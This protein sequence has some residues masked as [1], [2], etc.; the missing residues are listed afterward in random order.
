MSRPA[1]LLPRLESLDLAPRDGRPV[2]VLV[3]VDYN[4][5]MADGKVV[6]DLR[7][8]ES[9]R[10]VEWLL[11][12]DAVVV[13]CSH[14]GRPKGKVVPEL[15]LRPVIPSLRGIL[16]IEA[17]HIGFPPDFEATKVLSKARPGSLFLLENLRFDPREEAGDP[18]F[19]SQLASLADVYVNEA[20]SAS[21]R[22]HAS[23]TGV[24]A[25]LPSAAG[26]GLVHEV[27]MLSR[28]LDPDKR[29][30]VAVLGG[31]KVADKLG[32]VESLLAKVDVMCVGGGMALSFLAARGLEVGAGKVEPEHFDSLRAAVDEAE[33]LGKQVLVPSDLV[34]ADAFEPT[35]RHEV[36][37]A[38]RVPS[39]WFPLDIGPETVA[40]FSR[41]IEDAQTLFWNGPMGVFEWEAFSA[42]TAGVAEA[43]ARCGG[44][45]VAGGG[46]TA[47]ALKATGHTADISHLSTGGGASLEFVRDGDLVGLEALRR[48]PESP[49][50]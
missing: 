22:S 15:S 7:I 32:V 17:E 1:V 14:L 46:D 28:L 38:D 50:R 47:A 30:Y 42:G 44:F 3:R 25:L 37:R 13:L 24:P 23:V 29:P 12:R 6:D 48:S 33:A 35:A 10:T 26:F 18:E 19:A 45:T 4:V 16:G 31:A 34:V 27:T 21:H 36:C 43:V 5:P 39:G 49:R 41:A 2:R 20:F 11:Q 9:A 40:R 8:R